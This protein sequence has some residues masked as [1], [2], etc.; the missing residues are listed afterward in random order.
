MPRPLLPALMPLPSAL[1]VCTLTL[2]CKD[3]HPFLPWLCQY[4]DTA[5]KEG[6]GSVSYKCCWVSKV[7]AFKGMFCPLPLTL[8]KS[9]PGSTAW[10]RLR[11]SQVL[12]GGSF[13][14]AFPSCLPP[15]L[16]DFPLTCR[17][18]LY[19]GP[20]NHHTWLEPS[21]GNSNQKTEYPTTKMRPHS[22]IKK[23][24]KYHNSNV[25]SQV[26]KHRH[27]QL[28]Q[29]TFSR[30][31]QPYSSSEE[32]NLAK[33][34]EEGFKTAIMGMFKDIKEDMNKCLNENCGKKTLS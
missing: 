15:L 31:Q 16:C 33:A 30:S 10:S 32:S 12:C 7:V 1:Q 21:L 13:L 27:E 23:H 4:L 29:Y 6:S 9:I 8:E 26:K 17:T 2:P 25:Q 18:P 22:C 24:P 5:R 20:N 3:P 34:H 19:Q 28:R 14:S 11:V